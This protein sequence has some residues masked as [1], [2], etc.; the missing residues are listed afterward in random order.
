MRF[1]ARLCLAPEDLDEVLVAAEEIASE[2]G[3][4]ATLVT[5]FATSDFRNEAAALGRLVGDATGAGALMGCTAAGVV[6]GGHEIEFAPAVSL[7]ASLM[8]G[9][10][11][12]T[13]HVEYLTGMDEGDGAVF[14][15]LPPLTPEPAA[16]VVVTDPFTFPADRFCRYINRDHPGLA[17]IG[18]MSSGGDRAGDA[19]LILDA[20]AFES[21][22]VVATLEGEVEVRTVVSQG[23]RPIG[24]ALTVTRAE[25]NLVIEL[26]GAPAIDRLVETVAAL[27]PDE[28]GLVEN[29][30]HVGR[31]VDEHKVDFERGDF[32]VRNVLGVDEE[33]GAVAIGD[34]VEVGSTMRF[35]VRDAATA[36]EDL[37]YTLRDLAL[38]PAPMG[39]LLFTCNGRGRRFFGHPDHDSLGVAAVLGNDAVGGFFCAG[40]I[41]PIG[42]ANHLHG[43]TASIAILTPPAV[44]S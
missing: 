42:G 12:E 11:V 5:V 16:V 33:S 25:R 26:G 34:V 7:W 30:L 2:L 21:G 28:R 35:H 36:D 8:P 22:A 41:G 38:E 17:C 43:Y 6:A 37:D 15:G 40:E 31:V 20:T 23:C 10:T 1:A 44:R 3:D 27:E 13:A 9:V 24:Q 14:T 19:R 32:L 29:G 39:A 18:G 4:D